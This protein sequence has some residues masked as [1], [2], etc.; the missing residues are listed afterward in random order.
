MGLI[1]CGKHGESGFTDR[2]S[3]EVAS[4]IDDGTPLKE[5]DLKVVVIRMYDEDEFLGTN[6]YLL[7]EKEFKKSG[8]PEV[9][10]VDKE[11]TYDVI[12]DKLPRMEGAC[13]S[14][15]NNFYKNNDID[16]SSID[17]ERL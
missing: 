8:I 7:T 5:S 3:K 10:V 9:S 11:S 2:V 15:L 4:C 12:K 1:I 16:P 14:C 17:F 6:K 13:S